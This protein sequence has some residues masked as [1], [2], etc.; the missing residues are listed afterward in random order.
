[1]IAA[2]HTEVVLSMNLAIISTLART[3]ESGLPLSVWMAGYDD[4]NALEN[5]CH[6]TF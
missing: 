1:M 5:T 6:F 4:K 2:V 3:E